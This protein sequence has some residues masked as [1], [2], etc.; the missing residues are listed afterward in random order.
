MVRVIIMRLTHPHTLKIPPIS[1]L[2]Q[3]VVGFDATI[4]LLASASESIPPHVSSL[5]WEKMAVHAEKLVYITL[6]DNLLISFV[7]TVLKIDVY[8]S[9][10]SR[11][12][13]PFGC[14]ANAFH[15]CSNAVRPL[16]GM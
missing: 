8:R 15:T 14:Y 2:A 12:L 1:L 7:P 4:V 6:L 11:G 13:Y 9:P 3:K 5:L 16:D 10:M